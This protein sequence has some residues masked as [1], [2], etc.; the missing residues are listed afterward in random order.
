[1]SAPLTLVSMMPD[2][3]A[4][5]EAAARAELLPPGGDPGYALHAALLAQFGKALAPKPFVLRD[6]RLL[7]Y[8]QA[9]GARL[10]E[11]AALPVFDNAAL[12]ASL[13]AGRLEHRLMPQDFASGQTLDC[14]VRI[15]PVVRSRTGR[16]GRTRERDVFL[17]GVDPASAPPTTARDSHE[18]R[19]LAY[20]AWLAQAL[21]REGAG[22]IDADRDGALVALTAFRRTRL[23]TGPEGRGVEGPDAVLR[24]RIVV[25][26][27]AAFRALLRRGI[28]RARAFGF[29]MLLLAPPGRLLA[30]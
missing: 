8:V 27:P 3:R 25:A 19:A 15:R 18:P 1:M 29:G 24:A 28:G 5:S 20:A 2:L 21:E 22:R 10:V 14:E 16:E 4:L 26:D 17:A 11:A 6:G 23:H 7:G 12:A 13:R 30:R 9:D